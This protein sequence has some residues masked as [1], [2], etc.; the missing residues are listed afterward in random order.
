MAPTVMRM[1]WRDLTY[2]HW[3]VPAD[4]VAALLPPGLTP[5]VHGGSGWVGLVPFEMRAIRGPVGPTLP[6]L[7]SFAETN[8]R[9]YV[10]GPNSD[11]GVYFHSLDV[12]RAAAVAAAR[13]GYRLPYC[14]SSMRIERGART[15]RY[16]ATRRWPGPKG[17]VSDVRV[18]VGG[19]VAAPTPLDDFLTSR[20]TLFADGPA[21]LVRADVEHDEWPLHEARADHLDDALVAAAGYRVSGPPVHV[22]AT[23]GVN[24][25]VGPPRKVR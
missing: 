7:L 5:D 11:P 24:V 18:T 8:V 19:R 14:W 12:P 9:T 17:A 15:I 2:L 3:P 10:R 13:I 1:D 20:F 23:P 22:R 21:G 16:R 4:E 25:A 6:W